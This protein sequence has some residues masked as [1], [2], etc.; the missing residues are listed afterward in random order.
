MKYLK[1]FFLTFF[2]LIF[3]FYFLIFI[4]SNIFIYINKPQIEKTVANALIVNKSSLKGLFH[5]PF[6]FLKIKE[7]KL[8]DSNGMELKIKNTT[9]F[10]NIFNFNVKYPA[11]AFY[12]IDIDR[13]SFEAEYKKASG[14][15]KK[16]FEKYP[17]FYISQN[18]K[19]TIKIKNM[20]VKLGFFPDINAYF[21]INNFKNYISQNLMSFNGLVSAEIDQSHKINFVQSVIDF[22]IAL[23][24]NEGSNFVNLSSDFNISN[25]IVGG[26]PLIETESFRF[27][28]T[29]LENIEKNLFKNIFYINNSENGFSFE[30]KRNFNINYPEK[31]RYYLLEYL[32]PKGEYFA[33]LNCLF[34]NENF[35]LNLFVSNVNAKDKFVFNF[36]GNDIRKNISFQLNTYLFRK[37]NANLDFYNDIKGSVSF[38]L[39]YLK[40]NLSGIINLAYKDNALRIFSDNLK[41][42][43]INFYGFDSYFYFNEKNINIKGIDKNPG[44]VFN[45]NFSDSEGIVHLKLKNIFM[46]NSDS[47]INGEN[48]FKIS[49]KPFK[50][51]S[52]NI[53]LKGND[54]Q[55]KEIFSSDVNYNNNKLTINKLSFFDY[56]KMNLT[57]NLSNTNIIISG[58]TEINKNKIPIIGN[59]ILSKNSTFDKASLI[60]DRKIFLNVSKEK[61]KYSFRLNSENYS[62]KKFGID[63]IL[64]FNL[65]G[66]V[67]EWGIEEANLKGEFIIPDYDKFSISSKIILVNKTN[68]YYDIPLLSIENS[69][70]TL[71]GRGIMGLSPETK[72]ILIAFIRGGKIDFIYKNGSFT[73]D[74]DIQKFLVKNP[75]FKKDERNMFLT[76]KTTVKKESFYDSPSISGNIFLFDKR[77]PEYFSLKIDNFTFKNEE[78]NI[79]NSKFVYDNLNLTMSLYGNVNKFNINGKIIYD[80]IFSADYIST[81]INK[82]KNSYSAVYKIYNVNPTGILEDISGRI[83]FENNYLLFY[84]E[85]INGLNG[86]INLSKEKKDWKIDFINKNFELFTRGIVDKNDI[87][88]N[89]LYNTSLYFVNNFL[90]IKFNSGHSR[91]N[92]TVSGELDNPDINGTIELYNLSSS[93]NYSKTHITNFNTT[94]QVTNSYVVLNN[95]NIP[96]K[97]GNFLLNGYIDI[98]DIF[99]P[100]LDVKINPANQKTFLNINYLE[101]NFSL[102]GKLSFNEF[103]I[104]GNKNKINIKGDIKFENFSANLPVTSFFE[105][106]DLSLD[107]NLPENINLNLILTVGNNNKFSTPL[108]QFVFKKNSTL[109]VNGELASMNIKIKGNLAIERGDFTYLSKNFTIKEGNLIF[110]G[111]D[112]IPNVDM[113][114]WYR[115]R[116]IDKE[117]V[118]I[119]L[120]FE[121]KATKIILKDFYSV[122]E[123]PKNELALI[124]GIG[125]DTKESLTNVAT[126]D[127][128]KTGVGVAENLFFFNPLSIEIKRRIGLDVFSFRSTILQNYVESGFGRNTNTDFRDYIS[129]S[130]LIMGKYIFP[131]LFFEYELYFEKDPYSVYGLIPLHSLGLEL[132][133]PYFDVGWKYQPYNTGGKDRKY[134]Q[135][136]ELKFMRKF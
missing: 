64:N 3:G 19:N 70:D 22:S 36:S 17:Y 114:L 135:L 54:R 30:V 118:D 41:L 25:F 86:H 104:T 120:T 119:Y 123:K 94:L 93:V 62:I 38:D 71:L 32:M 44:L 98:R 43:D 48:S 28:S 129:G 91:G 73:L 96:T 69:Q 61:Q 50:I 124:L 97:T 107:K 65:I 117:N 87:S 113:I 78:L 128:L 68:S 72:R 122:P 101:R 115:Y 49:L 13:V 89:I 81:I 33:N 125:V 11:E 77:L 21:Y 7:I 34:K 136:L 132:D 121:G 1:F 26:I 99:T 59:I 35:N 95:I 75:I 127:Y 12:F 51:S 100:Y 14:Y 110:N 76:L 2:L 106:K 31:N 79:V 5:L 82:D 20:L 130:G 103:H 53:N 18:Q 131:V 112:Y 23:G 16:I 45:G 4:G 85:S 57:A 37:L 90:P 40:Q 111:E 47:F 66:S 60:F 74:T 52:L 63:S 15:L 126:S 29:N 83:A 39:L 24:I 88:I 67:S 105:T 84:S 133:L 58:T 109:Y 55:K 27:V 102:T 10:Y 56:L 8:S 9:V 6:F 134:E 42:N 116:D 92:I 80:N 108:N 46:K